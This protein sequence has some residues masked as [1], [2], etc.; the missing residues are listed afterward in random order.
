M[1]GLSARHEFVQQVLQ[2]HTQQSDSQ[3]AT[4]ATIRKSYQMVKHWIV[5][6]LKVNIGMLNTMKNY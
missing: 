3:E 1:I 4:C 6:T 5:S 2:S